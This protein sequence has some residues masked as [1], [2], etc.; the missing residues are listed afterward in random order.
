MLIASEL[1]GEDIVNY[2]QQWYKTTAVQIYSYIS[3]YISF[4]FKRLYFLEL[5]FTAILRRWYREF[6]YVPHLV[7]AIINILC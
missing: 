4:L 1:G 2:C 7:S 6:P 5:R 3:N